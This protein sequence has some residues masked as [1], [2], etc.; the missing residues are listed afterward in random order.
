MRLAAGQGAA[1]WQCR[2]WPGAAAICSGGVMWR[3]LYLLGLGIVAVNEKKA[4]KMQLKS[5]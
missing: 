4:G 5:L 1:G 3:V 2:T